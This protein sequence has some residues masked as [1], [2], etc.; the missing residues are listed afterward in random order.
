MPQPPFQSAVVV[1][2]ATSG[3][4]HTAAWADE[5][6]TLFASV[7]ITATVILAHSG[8]ELVS[9]ARK[10]CAAGTTLVVA[11]GG[12]GTINAVAA[13]LIEHDVVLGVL[14][15]GTLNHF[16]KDAGIPI[17]LSDAVALISKGQ[18][19]R[20]DVGEVNE[21]IFLN[22]S[23]LGLYPDIVRHREQQQHRLGR[24]KWLAFSWALWSALKRYPFLNLTMRI[25][26]Q[27]RQ[28]KTPFVFIGN[29]RYAMEGFHIGEREAL[30][31][32]QLSLYTT[33]RTGRLGLVR[34]MLQAMLGRIRQARD[35]EQIDFTSLLI[36]SRHAVMRVSTDGEVNMLP[37]P[38]RYRIRPGVLQ[39]VLPAKLPQ[40]ES[41]R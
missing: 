29:N 12:D 28:R 3:S 9:A 26:D 32:G 34:L 18:V 15:L 40:S 19:A 17:E 31:R 27:D 22:N 41:A 13:V 10:A 37:T 39:V 1:I 24:G 5:L 4:G 21:K 38:L 23:G 6:A 11:G 8:E 16:A 35:F 36:E 20:V 30:D 25:K 7:G 33:N 2:N 14:P